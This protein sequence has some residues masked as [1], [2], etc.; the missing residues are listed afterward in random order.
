MIL[1]QQPSA[2]E[3]DSPGPRLAKS[4][5]FSPRTRISSDSVSPPSPLKFHLNTEQA[6]GGYMM[7]LS[8]TRIAHFKRLLE[9]IGIHETSVEDTCNVILSRAT[10]SKS[11]DEPRISRQEYEGAVQTIISRG[12]QVDDSSRRA[13]EKVMS[14]IYDVFATANGKGRP[15]AIAIACGFTVLCQG[16]KSDKLEYAFEVLDKKKK[17]RLSKGDMTKYL[18]SFLTVLL[19]VAFSPS[20]EDDPRVD[21]LLTMK[22]ESCERTISTAAR[23]VKVGA[24]WAASLAFRDVGQGSKASMSFDD[25]ADWYTSKGFGDIPWLELIDLR[26]WVLLVS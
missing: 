6:H 17:G 9:I 13:L 22:G 10:T 11:D 25:F 3:G 16:K 14:E 19:A 1:M 20:L 23:V 7:A 18:Q 2:D 12:D 8:R 4:F 21:S 24:E 15:S 5:S 26:K